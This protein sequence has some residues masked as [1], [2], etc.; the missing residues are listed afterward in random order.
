MFHKPSTILKEGFMIRNS[1]VECLSVILAW[2]CMRY[3]YL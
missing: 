3:F 2:P 1:Y